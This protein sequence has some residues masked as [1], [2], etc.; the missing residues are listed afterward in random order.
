MAESVWTDVGEVF[1]RLTRIAATLPP[2]RDATWL[3]DFAATAGL[4]SGDVVL[5]AGGYA[6]YWAGLIDERYRSQSIVL[7]IAHNAATQATRA[8]RRALVGDV[9]AVP[10]ADGSV[11]FVWCRDMLSETNPHYALSE[12]H[13][14]LAAGGGL[15]LYAAFPTDRLE[16]IERDE[17]FAALD[18]ASQ[19][20]EGAQ[21]VRDLLAHVGFDVIEETT[22]SPETTQANLAA[23]G[24][25]LDDWIR[26]A[27]LERHPELFRREI[28]DAWYRRF[29]AWN[30]WSIYLLLGKLETVAWAASAR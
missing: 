24:G 11:D 18:I 17:L 26:L 3:V 13:R 12:F 23:G 21:R 8:A 2:P 19:W 4:K 9:A 6:G 16:S 20:G 1:G 14:V 30:R 7:D 5:D 28:G 27:Q 10:L 15:L 29:L 25:L 22:T